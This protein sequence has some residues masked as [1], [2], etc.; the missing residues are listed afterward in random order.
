VV[1]TLDSGSGVIDRSNR[2]TANR[3]LRA[4]CRVYLYPGPTHVKAT[5]VDGQWAYLGTG[6]FDALSLRHNRELGLAVGA[7]PLIQAL[8]EELFLPDFR[9][10]WE[11]TEPL[12]VTPMDYASEVIASLFL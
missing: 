9:P 2:V 7:G 10:E 1:L 8:E 6:N 5:S 11:V 12:P 4:G 3:L